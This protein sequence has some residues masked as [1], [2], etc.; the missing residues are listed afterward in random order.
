MKE[1]I[2]SDITMMGPGYC[3]IA[4]E[5][6]PANC[7]RSI[8]PLPGTG[9]AWREPFPYKRGDCVLSRLAEVRTPPP[10]NEDRQS[11]GFVTAN[12][13]VSEAQLIESLRHA[14]VA[15]SLDCLFQCQLESDT[16]S[17]NFWVKP[18]LAVRSICG[19]EYSEIKFSV[20]LNPGRVALRAKLVLPS[21]EV[22]F[23]LH[24]VDRDWNR[25]HMK[26]NKHLKATQLRYSTERYLNAGVVERLLQSSQRF[27]RIGLARADSSG[28]CWLMLD[29]LF[30]QPQEAWLNDE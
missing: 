24:V 13:F 28:K 17:G 6:N 11:H 12:R 22:F 27:A 18:E 23:S 1:L 4:L 19:C 20:Y 10:H 15:S 8:R 9:Y 5:K 21:R 7:F 29:S 16:P 14:E 3:V 30:P 2:L 26:L 25:F